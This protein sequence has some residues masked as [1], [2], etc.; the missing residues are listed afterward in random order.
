MFKTRALVTTVALA[1]V[2]SWSHGYKLE[3]WLVGNKL[4]LWLV[5]NKLELWLVGYKLA[6]RYDG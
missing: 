3:L 4:E 6:Q 2:T 5:G 1:L